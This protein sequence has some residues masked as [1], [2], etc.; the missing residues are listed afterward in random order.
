MIEKTALLSPE[1]IQKFDEILSRGLCRGKGNQ[2]G[3]MCIEAAITQVLDLPFSDQPYCVTK[4]IR[5]FKISLNDKKWS[6]PQARAEGLRNLG[7]AQIGSQ[8]IVNGNDF[9]TLLQIK[10]IKILIPDIF[11]RIYKDNQIILNLVNIC[12]NEPTRKNCLSL[13]DAA[14]DAATAIA[15]GYAA[16]AADDATAAGYAGYAAI[17]DSVATAAGYAAG[18]VAAVAADAAGYAADAA[19][20]AAD[21]A[22][23]YA[24]IANPTKDYYLILC[25]N[26]ALETLKEL[27]SPG[28]EWL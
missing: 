9:L 18:Y 4:E 23:G 27:K 15:A 12:E 8:G 11:R 1:R 3:Q 24:A 21:A 13:S 25:A 17:A 2:D 20:A 5:D 10:I 16:I 26:L 22:A 19:D 14:D 6:S 7:I 28:C